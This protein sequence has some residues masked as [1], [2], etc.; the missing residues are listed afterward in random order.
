MVARRFVD[1]VRILRIQPLTAPGLAW[2]S[3]HEDFQIHKY[4]RRTFDECMNIALEAFST[5]ASQHLTPAQFEHC[6]ND[7]CLGG[8]SVLPGWA[9]IIGNE[10]DHRNCYEI[11]II[12]WMD[13]FRPQDTRIWVRILVSRDRTSDLCEIRWLANQD[14]LP[15]AKPTI[16]NG[17]NIKP[18]NPS[19]GSGVF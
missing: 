12:D 9:A 17:K 11:R 15:S 8:G 13:E 6:M 18:L 10:P 1:R 2:P 5:G 4:K 7:A 16:E 3:L 14:W 19:S